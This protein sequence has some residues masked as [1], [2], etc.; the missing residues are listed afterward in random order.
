MRK[1]GIHKF[2]G[3]GR[4]DSHMVRVG[5][6]RLKKKRTRRNLQTRELETVVEETE[7][8]VIILSQTGEES[9]PVVDPD[10]GMI[11]VEFNEPVTV[12]EMVFADYIHVRDLTVTFLDLN[13]HIMGQLSNPSLEVTLGSEEEGIWTVSGLFVDNVSS[14]EFVSVTGGSIVS[15]TY[16]MTVWSSTSVEPTESFSPTVSP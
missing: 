1:N 16:D 13:G 15:F 8:P 4:N 6:K 11:T 2:F 12:T 14:I 5:K 3:R 10:G 9:D 7:E